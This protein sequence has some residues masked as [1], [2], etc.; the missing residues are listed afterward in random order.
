M[1][2]QGFVAFQLIGKGPGLTNLLHNADYMVSISDK[3]QKWVQ[4]SGNGRSRIA[5]I[6][7][8]ELKGIDILGVGAPSD[9]N[10]KK[11]SVVNF[12]VQHQSTPIGKVLGESGNSEKELLAYFAL[13]DNGWKLE[14]VE[15]KCG[16]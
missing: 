8:L 14:G 4:V 5:Q 6:K 11:I 9:T 3:A 13:Y 10:G 7:I 2:H 1:L 12:K 15:K 16:L